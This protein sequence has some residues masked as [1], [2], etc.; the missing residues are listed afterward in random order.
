MSGCS[1]RYRLLLGAAKLFL[2]KKTG[3]FCLRDRLS[4][5]LKVG[6]R[7]SDE[8]VDSDHTRRWAWPSPEGHGR[9]R[10]G[11]L[12]P[13]R[14][15]AENQAFKSME[16]AA[17]RLGF[18]LVYVT[19]SAEVEDAELD[20]VIALASTQPKA[21]SA[22]TFGMIHEPR[23]RFFSGENFFQNLLSYDGYLTI[24]DTLEAFCKTIAAGFGGFEE[25][26]FCYA[27]PHTDARICPVVSLADRGMLKLCYF[28]TNWDSRGRPI[29]RALS[30]RSYFR[31]YGPRKSW[32]Y[33]EQGYCG[34]VPFDGVSVQGTYCEFGAGLVMMS[35]D[36]L[37]DDIISN[38][39]FEISAV[40]AV[41]I[42]PDIPWIR[43]NFGDL[44]YY[45]PPHAAVQE[46][47]NAIDAAME[48][49]SG[50]PIAAQRR[51]RRARRIFEERFS[52]ERM[53]LN[54]A[55]YYQRWRASVGRPSLP[56]DDPLIDVI[57]R[58][59][60]RPVST[61]R[62][63]VESIEAQTAGRFRV[64]FVR[65]RP[66]SLEP[67]LAREW[68]RI[69]KFV[70]LD[71]F[72]GS[73]A[74]TMTVGLR[75][76]SSPYF[77]FLDDDDIW[78]SHH[79]A[80]LLKRLS[81]LPADRAYAYSGYLSEGAPGLVPYQLEGERRRIE[82]CSPLSGTIWDILGRLQTGVFLASSALISHINL[83]G[84]A[85]QSAEDSLLHASLIAHA[86]TAFTW[87]ASVCWTADSVG[88]SDYGRRASRQ[89]DVFECFG[90]LGAV[91]DQIEHKF[92]GRSMPPW[93]RLGATLRAVFEA[94]TKLIMGSLDLL[95]LDEGALATSLYD[96]D[97][98]ERVQLD[99]KTNIG[100]SGA[101]RITGG[102]ALEIL[103]P[104][105]PW[106]FGAIIRLP[107][108]P[109]FAGPQWIILEFERLYGSYGIGVLDKAGEFISRMEAPFVDTKMQL[110]LRVREPGQ[111]TSAVI[112][113]WTGISNEAAVLRHAWIAWNST[114]TDAQG[115]SSSREGQS[116]AAA[117]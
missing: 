41:S 55:D 89:E 93:E 31:I 58:V 7:T 5:L 107:H 109:V 24:S 116:S 64:L 42:C 69:Q 52:A 67:I 36:H 25:T 53:L 26:G 75:A 82:N 45:Y 48:S 33:L 60:G 37:L 30:E 47:V 27:T 68:T 38:R 117:R 28:G 79:I 110:W 44:V 71:E 61:I 84:W 78:L 34:S 18:S 108:P 13:W 51:A 106:A 46:I 19:T 35:K 32:S 83:D 70:V 105:Q 104:H 11:Y 39:I 115:R 91:L 9:L 99:L 112:Q 113:N 63:A 43:R 77:A 72:G 40:G 98:L 85:M 86:E 22:P 97:D 14:D 12:N 96:R 29:L 23:T 101:S 21:T 66:E 17:G 16:I 111:A 100:L 4:D 90:R 94:K 15:S 8:V 102:G 62:R 103:P 95:V 81:D 20:F 65:F 56:A 80:S 50:D 10:I 57:V 114:Q 59:G 88:A 1:Y 87:R 54:A 6:A 73:R 49:I 92:V 74:A 2:T 76:V 3:A